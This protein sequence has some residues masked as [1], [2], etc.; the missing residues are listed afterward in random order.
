MLHTFFGPAMAIMSRLRFGL[1]IGLIGLLFLAPLAA[2]L[3]HTYQ[4]MH[5]EI[6]LAEVE[7]L[8]VKEIVPGRYLLA[9]IQD[10]RG[11]S[12]LVLA[13]DQAAKERLTAIQGRVDERLKAWS[14]VD[15]KLS[16]TLKTKEAFS[17]IK[18]QWFELKAQNL[19]YT[20]DESLIKHNELVD[21]LFNFWENISDNSG[22]T[23]DSDVD[24]MFVG[25][26]AI[27]KIPHVMISIGRL[28]AWGARILDRHDMT[29]EEKTELVVLQRSYEDYFPDL[30]S[31]LARAIEANPALAAVLGPKIKELDDT[32]HI[33]MAKAAAIV[34]G[35][36][37]MS[38]PEY[39]KDGSSALAAIY[40]LFDASM[41]Q[42]D[43]LLAARLDR[44]ESNLQLIFGGMGATLLVVLYLF[45]GMLFSVLRSL[46]SIEAGA[47]R[48]AHGDVSQR[49][50]S[51]SSDELRTVGGAVNSVVET[52]QKFT[53]AQLD[54]ARAHNEE[55][56]TSEE[57]RASAFPGAYGDMAKN[58]NAMV[59]G[60][61]GVQTQFVGL[62]VEYA[63]G[64]FETRMAP[65][66]GERKA[67]S[68]TAER[69]RG[70]LLKAQDDAKE[71]LKIKIA[72]DNASSSLMMADNDGIIRYQNKAA[73]ALM[74]GSEGN[75]R[76]ALPGFSAAGV[77]GANFDQF[78]RNPSRQRNMLAGLKGE[79]RTQIQIGGLH[80][81]LVA[82][83]IADETGGRLGS[84]IEWLDRTAE[85]NAEKEIAAI[86]EAAGAG[87][88]AKRIAE[89]GKAGFF[90]EIA[91]G[92]NAILGTSEHALGEIS[93]ILKSMAQGDLAQTIDAEFKGVFAELK[94][95]SN[96][97][98]DRLREI[99]AQIREASQSINTAARE[100]AM[101]NNDLSRRTEE[102]ASSLEETAASLEEF[103]STV[104]Q[105]AENAAQANRLAEAA[106]ESAMRGGEVVGQVVSTMAGITDS[107]REIADITTLIDG[108]AFQTNLLALNA[109]VEAARAGE[110][111]RGFAVVA[112]EV[113]SLAQRAA[114]AA[115]SIKA[116]IAN[117]VGKVDEGA[118]LVQGA[119]A[120]MEEIVSQVKRVGAIV[121]EIAAAS[122]EQSSGIEQVNQAVT[123]I[124]QITQQNAA[125][126]EEATAAAKSLE[127]QSDA[128]VQ[129]V[130]VFRLS[131]ERAGLASSPR[132]KAN[133]AE[134][135][136]ASVH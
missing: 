35:D 96:G 42:L 72:L 58:L 124:D 41:E 54:M 43:K 14:E 104:R 120:A 89:A 127:E 132:P 32:A 37:R 74:R 28:R 66:P 105:N 13:G 111:G 18:K 36:F 76:A 94:D 118:R 50:D 122:K 79:H 69:L 44:L 135:A 121:G 30:K 92:L 106:S 93:R 131:S 119:G 70:V 48:L 68:D 62:M 57:M 61:I 88:F 19:R 24:S 103:A 27:V 39:F 133:G 125:L 49:V 87:D 97:T 12:Q 47:A 129:S 110:Q 15:E 1:K 45:G 38:G 86:V 84:V 29:P 101:G 80:M 2:L 33:F 108:I 126:V 51:R 90:L 40:G 109:A 16:V 123:S 5:T 17:K 7:R 10:H 6:Q 21:A 11:V 98:I 53:K 56:R 117:S 23:T 59:K 31:A 107:N 134:A 26:A 71:T 65:L 46:K 8:G 4:K 82:N 77:V 75:F 25:D 64:K 85:V 102:Q 52:L 136:N 22:L 9:E 20:A 115:K 55:G 128:L 3:V 113:R 34:N 130:A 99:I 91:R 114:E 63:G 81:R 112:S 73:D 83:P 60:H 116:V 100:I 95:N 78:H 67:I